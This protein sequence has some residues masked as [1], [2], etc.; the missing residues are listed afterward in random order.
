MHTQSLFDDDKA[1]ETFIETS[2]YALLTSISTSTQGQEDQTLDTDQFKT[3][4][5]REITII[6]HSVVFRDVEGRE[7]I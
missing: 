1:K 3:D 6:F 2:V 7:N 4:F 5:S